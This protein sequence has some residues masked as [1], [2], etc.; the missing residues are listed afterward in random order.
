MR[1]SDWSSDVCSSDLGRAAPEIG[2]ADVLPDGGFVPDGHFAREG[3]PCR[4]GRETA[5]EAATAGN[6]ASPCFHRSRTVF[7][8]AAGRRCT[9]GPHR[10]LRSPHP[11]PC[12]HPPCFFG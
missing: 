11:Q 9:K 8:F 12:P 5:P 2:R 7:L 1:I 4:Q 6:G 10:R 3:F